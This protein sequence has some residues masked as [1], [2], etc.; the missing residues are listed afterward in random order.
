[1]KRGLNF[2]I[3]I[4]YILTLLLLLFGC[5]SSMKMSPQEVSQI[6]HNEGIVVGSVMIKGGK[7]SEWRKQLGLGAHSWTLEVEAMDR[8]LTTFSIDAKERG[9]EAIFVTKIPAGGYRFVRLERGNIYGVI[10]VPFTVQPAKTIYIGRLVI[11]LP[12]EQVRGGQKTIFGDIKGTQ[13]SCSVEDAKEQTLASAEKTYGNL[14]RESVTALMGKE[15]RLASIELP[16]TFEKIW[17][18]PRKKDT[19]VFSKAYTHKGKVTI[20]KDALEFSCKEKQLTIPYSSVLSV[21]WGNVEDDKVYEW[22][23][24]TFDAGEEEKLAAFGAGPL[25]FRRDARKIYKTLEKAFADY[26]ASEGK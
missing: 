14:L 26:K 17:Y 13:F 23:I 8:M 3:R 6:K 11:E 25:W 16:R 5:E 1:M 4:F 24:L 15:L 12:R 2:L 10:N 20:T 19:S 21:R 7:E 22:A 18:R 9:D